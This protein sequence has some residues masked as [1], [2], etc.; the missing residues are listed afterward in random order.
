MLAVSRL[1]RPRAFC[2]LAEGNMHRW[3]GRSRTF[4]LEDAQRVDDD[5]E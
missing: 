4:V 5:D 2:A 1:V 3:R